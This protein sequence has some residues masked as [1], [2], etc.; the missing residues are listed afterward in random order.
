MKQTISF[1][2]HETSKVRITFTEVYKGKEFND[3]CVSE[4]YFGS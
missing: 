2:E 4:A 3:L 1:P